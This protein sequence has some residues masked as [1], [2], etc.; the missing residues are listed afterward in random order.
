MIDTQEQQ[1]EEARYALFHRHNQAAWGMAFDE[2]P[3][4]FFDLEYNRTVPIGEDSLVELVESSAFF[5]AKEIPF[6]VDQMG[7]DFARFD[8]KPFPGI[9]GWVKVHGQRDYGDGDFEVYL[10]VGEDK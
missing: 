6:D 2:V 7:R 1:T 3:T 10:Y 9:E 5:A 4:V 8:L